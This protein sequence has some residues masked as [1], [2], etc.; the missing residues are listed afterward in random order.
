MLTFFPQLVGFGCIHGLIWHPCVQRDVADL[1]SSLHMIVACRPM[2]EC[3]A[4]W[5]EHKLQG[6]DRCLVE[7]GPEGAVHHAGLEV[8]H[9]CAPGGVREQ[10]VLRVV[11]CAHRVCSESM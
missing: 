7:R 6:S 3:C 10:G 4:G 8:G 11:R 5:L 2:H 1:Y 9:A